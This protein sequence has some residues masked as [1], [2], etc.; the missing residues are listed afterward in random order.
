MFV[1]VIEL[2]LWTDPLKLMSPL[3]YWMLVVVTVLRYVPSDAL[4]LRVLM[5]TNLFGPGGA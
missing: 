4:A 5:I 1:S 2:P 3:K